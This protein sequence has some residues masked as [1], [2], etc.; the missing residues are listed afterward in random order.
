[1]NWKTVSVKDRGFWTDHLSEDGRFLVAQGFNELERKAGHPYCLFD[2][3]KENH[4]L[5]LGFY[6]SADEAKKA[7][8]ASLLEVLVIST[9]NTASM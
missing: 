8:P 2:I 7:A 1:M 5:V 9:E 4:W 3:S 6:S